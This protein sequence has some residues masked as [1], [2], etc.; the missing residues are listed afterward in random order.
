MEKITL[1]DF[2]NWKGEISKMM[3][4]GHHSKET[5]NFNCVEKIGREPF[6]VELKFITYKNDNKTVDTDGKNSGTYSGYRF[7]HEKSEDAEK[8]TV[9]YF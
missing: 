9:G 2:P 7:C 5:F 3:A 4:F 6:N 8:V 1:Y